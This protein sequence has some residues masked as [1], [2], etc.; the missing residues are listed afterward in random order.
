[1]GLSTGLISNEHTVGS[2]I[3]LSSQLKIWLKKLPTFD[4][5]YATKS[6]TRMDKLE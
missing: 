2:E 5:T 4:H 3:S 1:M 6:M